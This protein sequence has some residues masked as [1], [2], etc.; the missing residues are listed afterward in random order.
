MA[1]LHQHEENLLV[2]YNI[3]ELCSK[4]FFLIIKERKKKNWLH[5]RY[6]IRMHPHSRTYGGGSGT[7]L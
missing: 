3:Y 2:K 5:G 6:S 4:I 1:I 7:T